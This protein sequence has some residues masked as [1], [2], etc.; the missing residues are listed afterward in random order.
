MKQVNKITSYR[1]QKAKIKSLE[2]DIKMMVLFPETE[3]GL[4]TYFKWHNI[5]KK[6]KE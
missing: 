1:K 2:H 3:E 5:L 6:D 4:E